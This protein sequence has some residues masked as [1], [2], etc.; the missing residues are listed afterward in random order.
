MMTARTAERKGG[1]ARMP[2]SRAPPLFARPTLLGRWIHGFLWGLQQLGELPAKLTMFFRNP[3]QFRGSTQ[4]SIP[5]ARWRAALRGTVA[6]VWAILASTALS[7]NLGM[8][9]HAIPPCRVLDTRVSGGPLQSGQPRAFPLYGPPGSTAQN[10]TCTVPITAIG[11]LGAHA[12]TGTVTIV[13]PSADGFLTLF[14][15]FSTAVP[16][17]SNINFSAGVG[18][19]A[20][21]FT[22]QSCDGCAPVTVGDFPAG[23]KVVL[24]TAG[25]A[26]AHVIVDITGYYSHTA[27]LRPWAVSVDSGTGAVTLNIVDPAEQ[28]SVPFD[29]D[30]GDGSTGTALP[31]AATGLAQT[32]HTYANHAANQTYL[33]QVTA[34]YAGSAPHYPAF[35]PSDHAFLSVSF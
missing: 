9:L 26:T 17:T 35:A 3:V 1:G 16:P 4:R 24:G 7:D 22:S 12:V 29:I 34:H 23:L 21:G 14:P 10:A 13:Q 27:S 11:F 18:A 32:A 6:V 30:W 33:I 25:S 19:L 5:R 8:E 15:A 2:R 31:G 20:T 28:L